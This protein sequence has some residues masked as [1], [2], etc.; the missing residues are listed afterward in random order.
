MSFEQAS[1]TVSSELSKIARHRVSISD[2]VSLGIALVI[3]LVT[4]IPFDLTG[5]GIV[6]EV[7]LLVIEASFLRS[8][9]V[10]SIKSVLGAAMDF[11]PILDVMPWCTMAV[12]DKKFGVKI[13]YVTKIFNR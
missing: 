11:I 7:P 13:P 3:D 12:L 2:Y 8:L 5:I 4:A 9:G 10:S 1:P 6:I